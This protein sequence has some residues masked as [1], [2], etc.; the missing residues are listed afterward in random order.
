MLD[1]DNYIFNFELYVSVNV[2]QGDHLVAS[3]CAVCYP[4]I[5]FRKKNCVAAYKLSTSPSQVFQPP[6]DIIILLY[7][8]ISRISVIPHRFTINVS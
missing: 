6:G 2:E 8:F 1:N 3:A 4:E 7:S 5:L